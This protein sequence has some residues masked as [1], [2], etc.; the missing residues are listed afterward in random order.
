MSYFNKML[1]FLAILILLVGGCGSKPEKKPLTPELKVAIAVADMQWDGMK[2]MREAIDKRSKKEQVE[3]TWLDAMNNSQE[4]KRQLDK[5]MKKTGQQQFKTVVLQPVNPSQNPLMVKDLVKANIKVIAL[6]SLVPDVPFDGYIASDYVQAG[7]LQARYILNSAGPQGIASVLLLK[8]AAK[9]LAAQEIAAAIRGSLSPTIQVLEIE[10][11]GN[12]QDEAEAKVRQALIDKKIDAVLT[13]DSRL[14]LG[15]VQAL[16]AAG[17]KDRVITVG[18]GAGEDAARAITDGEHDAE[19]DTMP[20]LMGQYVFDAAVS[21]AKTGHWQNDTR[22]NN[23]NY[24]LPAKIIPVRLIDKANVYLLEQRWGKKMEG[25]G[26]SEKEGGGSSSSSSGSGGS[27]SNSGSGSGCGQ[28]KEGEKKAKSKL[29]I[30]TQEG[31]TVEVEIPGEVKK[32][33]SAHEDQEKGKEAGGRQGG[34]QGDSQ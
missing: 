10:C 26:G 8:C 14:A 17:L 15:A 33:E 13:T 2:V 1:I 23:G 25:K 3:V 31:K 21:L 5:L 19:V 32:I 6:E 30:T 16:K 9:D 24:S 18:V 11:S 4:Q 22:I 12:D 34:S 20:E 29:R 27:S 7:Q 28:S